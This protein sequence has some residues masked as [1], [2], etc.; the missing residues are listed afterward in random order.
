MENLRQINNYDLE[1]DHDK[2]IL[3]K[4]KNQISN[5]M[6][7][8]EET[9][10]VKRYE[11]FF[12]INN[13]VYYK[14]FKVVLKRDV[15]KVLIKLYEDKTLGFAH[16][17]T[18]FYEIVSDRYLNITRKETT[19]FLKKQVN[20][21]LTFKPKKKKQ[22]VKKFNEPHKAYAL[23]LIDIHRYSKYNKDK[24]FI[25]TMIDVYSGQV[26][27]RALTFKLAKDVHDVLKKIFEDIKPKLILMDNGGEFK[28][29]NLDFF[30]ELDIKIVYTPS[31]TPQPNI[32]RVNRNIRKILSK[33]FVENKDFVW[34]DYLSDIESNINNYQNLPRNRIKREELAKE[35]KNAPAVNMKPKFN[36]GDTVRV[37]QHV[38]EG[39]I[40]QEIKDGNQ[41]YIHVKYSVDLFE[42]VKI[43]KPTNKANAL[44]YYSIKYKSDGEIVKELKNKKNK[45][46]RFKE[47]DLL[48][49]PKDTVGEEI[50]HRQ[51]NKLNGIRGYTDIPVAVKRITRSTKDKTTDVNVTNN[52][53]RVTRST[54]KR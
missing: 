19:A 33:L 50:T 37:S 30:K 28:G 2:I 7:M 29:V 5:D 44:P 15:D 12:V 52:V 17:Y 6:T 43:Y 42:V 26:W 40:R 14:H 51:N 46:V 31:H 9:E 49:I 25:L 22:H 16:G 41:K 48:L 21:Q 20:Y 1:K 47:Q 10:F 34:V 45:I 13:E 18:Q 38:S 8:K 39:H 54:A 3:L 35:R 11:E 36:I 23:D 32:E 4:K 24:K 53:K 27:L